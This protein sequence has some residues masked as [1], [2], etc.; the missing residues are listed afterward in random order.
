MKIKNTLKAF[1]ILPH[2]ITLRRAK[3]WT[4]Q[5]IVDFALASPILLPLQVRSEFQR[6]AEIVARLNPKSLLEIGTNR[7]GTL[8]VLSRLSAPDGTIISLDLPGGEFGGGYK[9]FHAPIFKSFPH[10]NQKLHLLR[11]DSHSVQMEIA[12][13][14][15]V[16]TGKLDLLFIDGD[17]TYNGV[18]QD[19]E[20]YSA[21][22][23]PGGIVAFHDIV[24]HPSIR[25]DVRRLWDEVKSNYRHEE[26][27]ESHSQGWAGIGVLYV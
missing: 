13:R 6:F 20:T 5:D 19:F 4:P 9:W 12:V 7:G 16:G 2:V 25:C 8:C 14:E 3:H 21:L 23:R 15:I 1:Q 18:K 10:A 17:H 22:V 24:E 27:I 26:I 11:G